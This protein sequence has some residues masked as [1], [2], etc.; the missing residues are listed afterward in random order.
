MFSIK[1][2]HSVTKLLLLETFKMGNGSSIYC[3]HYDLVDRYGISV[4]QMTTDIFHL[5]SAFCNYIN[6]AGGTSGAGTAYLPEHL[7]SS[8]VLVG[9]VLLD[10]QF[11]VYVFCRSL[12]VPLPFFFWPLCCLSLYL[13]ILITALVS[14]NSSYSS[15]IHLS[16][17]D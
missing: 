14:S 3:R 9:F 5:S 8:S 11:Y 15:L 16:N 13:R 2:Q 12:F 4:S 6:T 7:S 10:L 1:L 17:M